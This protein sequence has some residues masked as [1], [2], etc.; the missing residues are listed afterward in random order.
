MDDLLRIF[1]A[2]SR[3]SQSQQQQNE[4]TRQNPLHL[5]GEF[6]DDGVPL[7]FNPGFRLSSAETTLEA[8]LG[9]TRRSTIDSITTSSSFISS[10]DEDTEMVYALDEPN[11]DMDDEQDE[12]EDD[13]QD[14]EDGAQYEEEGDGQADEDDEDDEEQEHER[15]RHHPVGFLTSLLERFGI[16]VRIDPESDQSSSGLGGFFNMVSNPG[17]YVFSQGALDDVITQMME[18]Q[19]RQSGPVG[20]SDETIDSIPRR[21]LT[22][23]ELGFTNGT[24]NPS[25]DQGTYGTSN[26][27]Q[28]TNN[29]SNGYL[30]D[31]NRGAVLNP[32]YSGQS[33]TPVYSQYSASNVNGLVGNNN[34]YNRSNVNGYVGNNNYN[35]NN[36]NGFVGGSSYSRNNVNGYVGS[37]GYS[38]NNVNGYFGGNNAAGA[39]TDDTEVS[40]LTRDLEFIEQRLGGIH[41]SYKPWNKKHNGPPLFVQS[42][43][44]QTKRDLEKEFTHFT[45]LQNKRFYKPMD[46]IIDY[47]ERDPLVEA[48]S[49]IHPPPVPLEYLNLWEYV[50]PCSPIQMNHLRL[51][52]REPRA[53]PAKYEV[54]FR[55]AVNHVTELMRLPKKL[56]MPTKDS[57]PTVRYD[58]SKF[59]GLDYARMKLKSRRDAHPQALQDAEKVWDSLLEGTAVKPHDA[60][61]GGKGKLIEKGRHGKDSNADAGNI[62]MGRLILM[63]SHRDLLILGSL[64]QPLTDAYLDEQWPIY[65]GQSWYYSGAERFVNKMSRHAVYHCFDAKKFDAAIDGWLVKEALL[66]LRQQYE[67]GMDQKYD[68]LWSFVYESLVEVV[69]CRDDGIRM[70]KK[71]G[72]TSGNCFNTLVQS[73]ITLFL[74]YTA[75]IVRAQE[76]MG[77]IGVEMVLTQCEIEVLGDDMVMALETP[78]MFLTKESLAEVVL[79]CFNIDWSGKKSFSTKKLMDDTS[80]DGSERFKGVQFLGMYFRHQRY[81]DTRYAPKI[82][83]PY[84]PFKES[85]L[86]LLF[87]KHGDYS[88]GHSWLR[89][90]GIYLNAAGNKETQEWLEA[91][92]DFLELVPFVRPEAWPESMIRMVTRDFWT[93]GMKAPPPVRITLDKWLRLTCFD[94]EADE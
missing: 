56:T 4:T 5:P 75:L 94:K 24:R 60:R 72:T 77:S 61:L 14:R 13:D 6:P 67:G 22:T 76:R 23:G 9:H 29:T 46:K 62:S 39:S 91:Y 66:I 41:I 28:N 7:M 81:G 64:E 43:L 16:E 20:A 80:A 27:F 44:D 26:Q 68:T 63:L 21:P 87:P 45:I 69:I 65:I 57:L 59:A 1:Q 78:W 71:V 25:P 17:D 3:S 37:N 73:I 42:E 47:V 18:A 82:V 55:R 34:S 85:Y 84:R 51:F 31:D 2:I 50:K 49:Q 48:F 8:G 89:A 33:S 90:I 30:S 19:N 58:G 92:L 35:R 93:V 52:N 10:D 53:M 54:A 32:P 12:D 83:V 70:Q 88:R 36:V 40:Q 11:Y 79:D 86:S 74:G 38:R 15:Q